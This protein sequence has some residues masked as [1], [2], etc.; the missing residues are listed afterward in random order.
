MV[1]PRCE[2]SC[3]LIWQH[4]AGWIAYRTAIPR[5]DIQSRR[6]GRILK[7]LPVF[8][9]G[10][11]GI[12]DSS[13]TAS[14]D[15]KSE[16]QTASQDETSKLQDENTTSEADGSIVP[17]SEKLDEDIS[18]LPQMPRSHSSSIVKSIA[19]EKGWSSNT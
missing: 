17:S 1:K 13:S 19:G 7:I 6:L 10:V 5:D 4:C 16:D 15:L 2:Q 3:Q 11:D 9:L 12:G 18:E 8:F 14:S